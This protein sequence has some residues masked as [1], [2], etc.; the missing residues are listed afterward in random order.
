MTLFPSLR[1][2]SVLLCLWV[3][4]CGANS[5]SD[6][7]FADTGGSG[8][9]GA[10]GISFDLGLLRRRD[11]DALGEVAEAG[12]GIAIGAVPAV[13]DTRDGSASRRDRAA[14]RP[15]RGEG[16]ARETAAGLYFR[17]RLFIG[18]NQNRRAGGNRPSR[19]RHGRLSPAL[20]SILSIHSLRASD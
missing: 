5:G 9:A 4:G 3:V 12:L 20:R 8:S 19:P 16:A 2:S 18:Q 11:E 17:D 15:D 1:K 6:N 10:S 13:D 7:S 14:A